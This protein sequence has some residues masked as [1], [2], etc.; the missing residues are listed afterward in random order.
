VPRTLRVDAD[1]PTESYLR[2][3]VAGLDG[4]VTRATLE[5][6]VMEGTPDGPGIGTAA[7]GLAEESIDWRSR[8][9][10][11]SPLIGASGALAVGTWVAY[12]VTRF[13]RGNGGYIFRLAGGS[14]DGVTFAAREDRDPDHRPRLVIATEG[15]AIEE[16]PPTATPS[17]TPTKTPTKAPPT[18]ATRT[19]TPTPTRTRTPGGPPGGDAALPLRAAFYYPWFPGAWDQKG[20][21]PY[22]NYAPSLGFYDG[23]DPAVLAHHV[24]A[25]QYGGIDAAIASWWGRGSREDRRLPALL[26]AAAGTGFRWSVY[27]EDEGFGDPAVEA[28]RADLQYLRDAYAADPGF[29]RLGGRFVVFVYGGAES[30]ATATR[31]A[32]ANAAVGAY[33]VLK[34][35]PG[36]RQCA[37]QPD[38]WHQYAPAAAA[39]AQAG[40]SYSISPGFWEKGAPVRLGRDLARWRQ[41]VRD[42]VASGAPFQL[43]TTFNEW[44]E[45]TAVE[46]AKEWASASGYGAYLDALHADGAEPGPAPPRA[47]PTRTPTTTPT[48]PSTRTPTPTPTPTR[49]PGGGTGTTA[50]LL[51]AGDI[52]TCAGAGDEATAKLLDGLGGTVATL[53][54]NVYESGSAQQYADCYAPTWG[55]HKARTRPAPGNHDYQ[56]AGAAGYFGYFGGAAGTP[57]EGWYSYD[58]GA[59]HV[60][61]LNSNLALAAGSAQ[62]RWLRA[63]LAANPAACTLAYWHH[64]RFSSGGS[65]G[66]FAGA[67]AAWQALYAAGADV[68]LGGHEHNY[69]RFAPQDPSGKA[70]P[71][72]GLRQFVVGTGGKGHYGFAAAKA[73]SE[74]R[75]ADAFGVLRLTLRPGGYDW[76]FVPVAG[77]SFADRGTGACHGAPATA[78][79]ALATALTLEW[80]PGTTGLVASGSKV[81]GL[82]LAGILLATMLGRSV[83]RQRTPRPTI[84]KAPT[85]K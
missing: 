3:A 37:D 53:G 59:W 69:E 71:A 49:T 19:P 60:V 32:R 35:F 30:C 5:L 7:G 63:D 83:R 44:G 47:T 45:G 68:V 25:M 18:T 76:A 20:I 38:A 29:L 12:D 9:R 51:A 56:T 11:T 84:I 75:N 85:A 34:V 41:N 46:S 73:N 72:F 22:T 23:G 42:M 16:L 70:D 1:P 4:A 78:R 79:G 27:Y 40:H 67:A 14:A 36:Y 15:G 57:G 65:H 54:D 21:T 43:V 77:Q 81:A 52:A 8:P 48:P 62:E 82:S 28:I 13:V 31:W 61:V 17:R 39:D 58:L 64:P 66:N 6:W 2:F 74:A 33:L 24:A 10:S 55:R 50:T 80:D 26:A